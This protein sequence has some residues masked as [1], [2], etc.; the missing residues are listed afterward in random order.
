M[1]PLHQERGKSHLDSSQFWRSKMSLTIFARRHC[2][3]DFFIVTT[4]ARSAVM[5]AWFGRDTISSAPLGPNPTSHWALTELSPAW[6]FP[7][8]RKR[9]KWNN[10]SVISFRQNLYE[11]H[12]AFLHGYSG[13]CKNNCHGSNQQSSLHYHSMHY[14]VFRKVSLSDFC[15]KLTTGWK[16]HYAMLTI[17]WVLIAEPDFTT[18]TFTIEALTCS[19]SMLLASSANIVA[20]RPWWPFW[21]LRDLLQSWKRCY[22]SVWILKTIPS[23]AVNSLRPLPGDSRYM[24]DQRW[25]IVIQRQKWQ[26]W[27]K[28]QTWCSLQGRQKSGLNSHSKILYPIQTWKLKWGNR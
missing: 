8:R 9:S 16:G 20:I 4:P 3:L 14:W 19:L 10:S 17:T 5:S 7:C 1:Q 28:W 13:R 15:L 26:K 6:P 22:W 21:P 25:K 12:D 27:P 11:R 18:M 24:M 23:C 2:A